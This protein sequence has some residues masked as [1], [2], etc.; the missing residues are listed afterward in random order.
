[1]KGKFNPDP[2]MDECTNKFLSFIGQRR[3]STRFSADTLREDFVASWKGTREKTH[4][5]LLDR[6][7]GHYKAVSRS[8]Q[9]SEANTSF[10]H[11]A[12]K[13]GL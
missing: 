6:D 4:L 13:S 12:S 9:I 3:K 7:F 5:S 10:Q 8:N 2:D 1:M 11:V